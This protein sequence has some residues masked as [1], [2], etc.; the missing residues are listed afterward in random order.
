[1]LESESSKLSL[2][3]LAEINIT[4]KLILLLHND[5]KMKCFWYQFCEGD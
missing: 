2:N 5:R 1:M 4:G 3:S